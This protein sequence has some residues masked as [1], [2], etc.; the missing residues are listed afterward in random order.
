[1]LLSKE[2]LDRLKEQKRKR[3][4][5]AARTVAPDAK[6]HEIQCAFFEWVRLQE[7]AIPLLKLIFA[8]PN[9]GYRSKKTAVALKRE[10][11]K[12]GIPDVLFPLATQKYA[13]L[14]LEFKRPKKG[15][16]S[17]AQS[18]YIE[19]LK[20]VGWRVE[21]VRSA[22]EAINLVREHINEYYRNEKPNRH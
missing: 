21:V 9:G 13:G 5:T 1:M 19:Q 6:E 14:A 8:V 12:A 2:T 4:E 7:N 17:D 20:S 11:A 3:G 22:D 10:G 18:E 15:R 16:L